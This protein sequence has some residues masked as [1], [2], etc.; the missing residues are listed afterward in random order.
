MPAAASQSRRPL[1]SQA[2]ANRAHL[3]SPEGASGM[4]GAGRIRHHL[5]SHQL[6]KQAHSVSSAI[7]WS[8]HSAQIVTACDPVNVFGGLH[9]ARA[10]VVSLDICSNC[11]DR[12]ELKRYVENISGNP[13]N[14]LPPRRR[15][16]MSCLYRNAASCET[17]RRNPRA[18]MQTC[19]GGL[20]NGMVQLLPVRLIVVWKEG[21]LEI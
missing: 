3:P 6:R 7:A 4:C 12:N 18:G 8:T 19:G 2:G 17:Q 11:V 13:E 9:L 10:K 21:T 16:A 14:L 5:K 20:P 1:V 15:I